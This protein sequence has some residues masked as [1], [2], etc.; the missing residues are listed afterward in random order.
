MRGIIFLFMAKII[1]CAKIQ[2]I[3]GL[4]FRTASR[5]ISHTVNVTL[6]AKKNKT[7]TKAGFSRKRDSIRILTI[8]SLRPY[9]FIVNRPWT[10]S[11]SQTNPKQEGQFGLGLTDK[12]ISR[13]HDP[14]QKDVA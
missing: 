8:E 11:Q 7:P 9:V 10:Q 3:P 12:K 4:Q 2:G 14:T 13:A 5:S 6:L 1:R